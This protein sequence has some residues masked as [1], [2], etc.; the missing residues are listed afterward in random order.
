[1][2]ETQLDLI[3]KQA[4]VLCGLAGHPTQTWRSPLCGYQTPYY[5]KGGTVVKRVE[6]HERE[7]E[8]KEINSL[9]EDI[10]QSPH[11]SL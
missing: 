1:M 3:S 11:E 10:R 5:E 9:I 4:Q 8:E 6:Q 2:L 7:K